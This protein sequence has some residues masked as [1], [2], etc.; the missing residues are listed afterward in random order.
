MVTPE[1]RS[2]SSGARNDMRRELLQIVGE[3]GDLVGIA[4]R[5]TRSART[6]KVAEQRLA[7]IG[8]AQ[9]KHVGRLEIPVRNGSRS[10]SAATAMQV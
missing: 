10:C 5:D 7:T 2:K 6:A 8:A 3:L 1:T 4:D 9:Q